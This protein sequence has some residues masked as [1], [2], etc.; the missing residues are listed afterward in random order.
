MVEDLE[1]MLRE[2]KKGGINNVYRRVSTK[3]EF[4]SNVEEFNPDIIIS[5]YALPMFNG[6]HAFRL[7][8]ERAI[9]TPFILVTGTLTE[10][11]ALECLQEGVDDFVLKSNLKRLPSVI[12]RLLQMKE[13]QKEKDRIAKELELKNAQLNK[14]Q[15]QNDHTKIRERLSKREFEILLLIAKGRTIKEI[16]GFLSISPATVATHRA[17]I[18]AKLFLKSNVEITKFAFRNK[19][20]D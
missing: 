1:L 4:L 16:A 14:L 5:D 6:M 9:F 20:I 3:K 19:L 15:V 18:L 13:V 17:R 11:L 2:I 12:L 7:V 10:E 8:R